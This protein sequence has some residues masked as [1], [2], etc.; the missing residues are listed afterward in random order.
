ME[1][2]MEDEDYFIDVDEENLENIIDFLIKSL[3]D[4]DTVVRWSAAKGI[5]RITGF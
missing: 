3:S 1:D 5:G 2:I 4:K